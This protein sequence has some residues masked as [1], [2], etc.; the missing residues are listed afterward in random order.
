M[1]HP[2]PQIT[3][4]IKIPILWVRMKTRSFLW[5]IRKLDPICNRLKTKWNSYG[6]NWRRYG[7]LKFGYFF[8][9]NQKILNLTA[10]NGWQIVENI[11]IFLKMRLF[12]ALNYFYDKLRRKTWLWPISSSFLRHLPYL[13]TL[14]RRWDTLDC[15]R[16]ALKFQYFKK[17]WHLVD[18][19]DIFRK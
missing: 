14:S 9:I 3:Y 6:Q 8:K 7:H 13:V 16:T 1:R 4:H 19:Y 10:V 2:W 18:F 5:H 11:E 17:R 15:N 12:F